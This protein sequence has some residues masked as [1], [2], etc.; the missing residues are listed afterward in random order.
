MPI[1]KSGR[2]VTVVTIFGQDYLAV[3]RNVNPK[4]TMTLKDAKAINEEWGFPICLNRDM[5][6]SL[7][8]MVPATGSC[9]LLGSAYGSVFAGTATLS[10][11]GASYSGTVMI[12]GANHTVNVDDI[13]M[14][15]VTFKSAGTPSLTLS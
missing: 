9:A 6:L 11:G 15:N 4:V 13:Q 12:N 14:V 2:N 3:V 7:D 10:L 5:D 1:V 8:L